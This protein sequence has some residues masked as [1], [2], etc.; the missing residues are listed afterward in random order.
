MSG[1]CD[2]ETL[3]GRT[4]FDRLHSEIKRTNQLLY[5]V[6]SSTFA[7]A[8]LLAALLLLQLWRATGG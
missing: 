7:A 6:A 5:T 3:S 4:D 2:Y 1:W 8:I